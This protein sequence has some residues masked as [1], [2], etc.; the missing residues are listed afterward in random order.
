LGSQGFGHTSLSKKIKSGFKVIGIQ[1][2][3]HKAMDE[4]T[5]PNEVYITTII[6]ILDENND[7]FYTLTNDTNQW[8]ED[9]VAT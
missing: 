5:R 1:L 7:S 9:G 4:K 2:V 3:N 8:G 6:H